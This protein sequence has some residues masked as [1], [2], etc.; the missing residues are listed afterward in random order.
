MT[1]L[2]FICLIESWRDT[3]LNIEKKS[4]SENSFPSR[5]I[6]FPDGPKNTQGGDL[7]LVEAES[8]Q[9][10]TQKKQTN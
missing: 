2:S 5:E 1:V 9:E 8:A 7:E 3:G 10:L 4:N 6:L